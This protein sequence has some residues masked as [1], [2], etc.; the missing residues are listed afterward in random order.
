MSADA[1]QRRGLQARV[2]EVGGALTLDR[3]QLGDRLRGFVLLVK[4][5]GKVGAGGG[6]GRGKLE[7]SSEQIFRIHQPPDPCRKL[8]HHPDRGDIGRATLEVR[9]KQA[10]GGRQI[11]RR[12]R[13][14]RAKQHG[15]ARRDG[16]LTGETEVG[17]LAHVAWLSEQR[18]SGKGLSQGSLYFQQA[19]DRSRESYRMMQAATHD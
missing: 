16:H 2:A 13:L 14:T 1:S 18:T 5:G 6:K 10:F 11:V 12:Q 8:G 7:R 15:I 19:V 4:D 9:A 17:R 3:F